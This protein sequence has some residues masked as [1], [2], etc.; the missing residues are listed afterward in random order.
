MKK[1]MI[2]LVPLC[3]AGCQAIKDAGGYAE[4]AITAPPNAVLD[5]AKSILSFIEGILGATFSLLLHGIW[6]NFF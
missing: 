5:A 3:L 4:K 6:P 1:L 2:A